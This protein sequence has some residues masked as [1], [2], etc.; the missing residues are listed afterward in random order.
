MVKYAHLLLQTSIHGND[1]SLPTLNYAVKLESWQTSNKQTV[2]F[3]QSHI[4]IQLLITQAIF[5]ATTYGG[6]KSDSRTQ[7]YLDSQMI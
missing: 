4:N 5:F 7:H 6:C 3:V 1:E 2:Y